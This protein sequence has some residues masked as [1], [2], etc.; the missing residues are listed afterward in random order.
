MGPMVVVVVVVV[1]EVEGWWWD[2]QSGGMPSIILLNQT[3]PHTLPMPSF[4]GVGVG[5]MVR[6]ER[7]G[8]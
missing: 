3:P 6:G 5:G 7:G 8:A 4:E 1:E 2:H